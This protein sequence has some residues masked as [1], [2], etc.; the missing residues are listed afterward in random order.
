[1][2]YVRK[3][4]FGFTE[5][6]YSSYTC[7]TG[8][9]D[10]VPADIETVEIAISWQWSSIRLGSDALRYHI[11]EELEGAFLSTLQCL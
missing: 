7:Y 3:F 10:F 2:I 5:A 1:M 11:Q 4:L 9:A 6:T 8:I